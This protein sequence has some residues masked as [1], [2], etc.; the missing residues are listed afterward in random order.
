MDNSTDCLKTSGMCAFPKNFALNRMQCRK[1]SLCV[2]I[3]ASVRINWTKLYD[4]DI[5][6]LLPLHIFSVFY[7]YLFHSM[8]DQNR[9]VK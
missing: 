4:V 2:Y 6:R 5:R 1:Y 3:A 8:R 9:I 7:M